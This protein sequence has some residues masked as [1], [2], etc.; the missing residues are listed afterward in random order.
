MG[1][2]K[3]LCDLYFS[4]NIRLIKPRRKWWAGH[5]ARTGRGKMCV[6]VC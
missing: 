2:N 5:V 3:E 6:G 1:M 4:P